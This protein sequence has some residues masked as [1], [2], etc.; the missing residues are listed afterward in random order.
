MI[1]REAASDLESIWL[2]TREN[3]SVDQA[4]K[5]HRQ[6][7]EVVDR[8]AENPY[9]GKDI[10]YM[11]EGYYRINAQ[12]HIIFYKIDEPGKNVMIVRILHEKMDI[13]SRL[14]DK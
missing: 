6:L 8:L 7:I 1:S 4:D 12:A 13:E 3:W 10:G 11:Y 5:Y 14:N 9:L 2:Y